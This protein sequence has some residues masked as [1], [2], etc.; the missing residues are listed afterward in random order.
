MVCMG[1]GADLRRSNHWI[2]AV[3]EVRIHILIQE[4]LRDAIKEDGKAN[5]RALI[6]QIEH[7]LKSHYEP[8]RKSPK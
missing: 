1:L 2:P 8:K 7:V 6:R 4:P 5:G 3:T